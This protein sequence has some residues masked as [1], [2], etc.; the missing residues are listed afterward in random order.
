MA[1]VNFK[2]NYIITKANAA[3]ISVDLGFKGADDLK[4]NSTTTTA[5]SGSSSKA[6]SKF[7]DNNPPPRTYNVSQ[8]VT[9]PD[10]A[11][12]TI[13]GGGPNDNVVTGIDDLGNTATWTIVGRS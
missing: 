11:H 13:T 4:N 10:G 1:A 3:T 9:F 12:V 8:G 6:I 5:V 7:K 2:N